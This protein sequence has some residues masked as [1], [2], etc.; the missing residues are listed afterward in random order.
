MEELAAEKLQKDPRV[1]EGKRLLMEAVAEAQK[2]LDGVRTPDRDRVQDYQALLD[3][4]TKWRSSPLYYNYLSSGIGKGAL[5]ELLD[6]SVKYDFINGIGPHPGHSLP[7]MVE[8][9]LDAAIDDTIMQGNLQQTRESIDLMERLCK[10]SNFDHCFLSTTGAMACENALKVAFQK[11]FPR[12]RVLAF[13]RCFMGRTLV[14]S[15]ITD[16]AA[17]REGL[18]ETIAV[19]YIPFFDEAD[20][21]GST[22]RALE[23]LDTTLGRYKDEHAVMV[24]ELIQGE[25]G[26]RVGHAAFFDSIIKRLRRA[27]IMVMIDEVQTFGRTDKL[28]AFQHF[29]ITDFDLLTIGKLSQVCATLFRKDHAP[30]PGLLSQTFTGSTAAIRASHKILD[31]LDTGHAT[32]I[33][34]RFVDHFEAIRARHP[35]FLSGP[36]GTGLMIAFQPFD[37]SPERAVA[38]A[39]KLFDNGVMSFVCGHGPVRIRF[40]VPPLAVTEGDVDGVCEILEET[41]KEMAP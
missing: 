26:F 8:A 31:C 20:P 7:H 35:T 30:K 10:L 14:A 18:P 40:L 17:Y 38:V 27:N 3:A 22:K 36:Y 25:G 23:Q 21:E 24:M 15:R 16:R 6:G 28:F 2:S 39:K 4:A 11:N 37:G 32:H 9:A 1:L 34:T 29:N 13:E 33:H 19:D 5:V 41:L 12:H